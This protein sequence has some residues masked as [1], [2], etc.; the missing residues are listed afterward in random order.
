MLKVRATLMQDIPGPR[1]AAHLFKLHGHVR[2][3][4]APHYQPLENHRLRHGPY[5][6][7][8]LQ[9]PITPYSFFETFHRRIVA[10]FSPDLHKTHHGM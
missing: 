4:Y 5:V 2:S 10:F 7:A 9:S 3:L 1:H 6:V 8:R